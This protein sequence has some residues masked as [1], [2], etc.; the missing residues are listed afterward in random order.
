MLFKVTDVPTEEILIII[1][2]NALEEMR[3]SR[4]RLIRRLAL[5]NE[6]LTKLDKDIT[7]KANSIK[8][9]RA[10]YLSRIDIHA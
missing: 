8:K 3:K 5:L 10:K 2:E 9:A 1:H 4:A 6:D 7:L